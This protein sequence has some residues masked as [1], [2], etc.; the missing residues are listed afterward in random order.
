MRLLP[1]RFAV[2]KPLT[3][4][5]VLACQAEAADAPP[6]P[7]SPDK[8]MEHI[9]VLSSDAYEGRAP[10]TPGE[11]ATVRYVT[12][13]FREY[14]LK[15]GNP[16]GSYVQKVPMVGIASQPTVK[17]D[18]C[19]AALQSLES[20]SDYVATSTQTREQIDVK[21][22]DLVFVGYGV[23]APEYGWDDYKDVD[24]HGKT[25]VMLINDP[26]V[27][28][29]KDQT[30]LDDKM[31]KG[32]EM[33]YYGR[34][35]YKYEIA[36]A[37][38]AAGAIIIHETGP[39][40]YPYFVIMN[41]WGR[42]NFGIRSADGNAG[43]VPVRSWLRLDRAK[44]MLKACGQDYDAL[45]RA[46]ARP[47]FRPIQLGGTVDFH[48]KQQVRNV[49]TLNVVA[50]LDG[51]DAKLKNDWVIYSAHWDH[52]GRNPLMHGNPIY[53]GAADNASGTA[54]LL[55]LARAY[56]NDAKAGK[57][58]KR[59]V[60]FMATTAEEQGLL[61][62]RY[63]A[64]NPLYPLQRTVADLNIDGINP[65]GLTH[66]V[67]V[68]GGRNSSMDELLDDAAKA[69]GRT[70]IQ[71]ST[72]E[73][74]TFY[75]A[76]QFEFAKMG[77]PSLYIKGGD[78]YIGKPAAFGRQKQAEYIAKDYHQPSDVIKPDWDL[79]GGAQDMD[80]LYMVGRRL[81]DGNELL[82]FYADSEFR[83][84]Q[85]VLLGTVTGK[86]SATP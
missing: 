25:I 13:R 54:A 80:L 35:T 47:D 74:G 31:F 82:H 30:K 28:D 42:E 69:Q 49:D 26:Q 67:A 16:D 85:D 83:P 8:L 61:G 41:S 20:P 11:A 50:K 18:G 63:Y 7:I 51:D 17:F 59:S 5:A 38:G 78:D 72:P 45:K 70:V 2:L 65:W 60:L 53:H 52:L 12:D 56:T 23:V 3:V 6:A 32:K 9:K 75:R 33:T 58:P 77:V 84:K 40:G 34:W 79:R 57:K 71:D 37:K 66:D 48:I 22:S 46:A 68:I 43:D 36:A 19:A 4:A 10:G 24:V 55:E 29:P 64:S 62:A 39:A 21:G 86:G 27:P 15:P 73:L 44:T 81:S 14:G 1:Y 76:D